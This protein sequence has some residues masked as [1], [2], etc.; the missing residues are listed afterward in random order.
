MHDVYHAGGRADSRGRGCVTVEPGIYVREEGLG[1][2]LENDIVVR[3]AGNV[4]L[5]AKV[6]IEAEEVE[7]MMR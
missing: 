7:R 5:M 6:P 4:D 3:K 1:I 2:R